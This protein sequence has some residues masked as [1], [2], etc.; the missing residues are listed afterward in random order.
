MLKQPTIFMK[1]SKYSN[2]KKTL[3]HSYFTFPTKVNTKLSYA[4]KISENFPVN[5]TLP[6]FYLRFPVYSA[7]EKRHYIA[8]NKNALCKFFQSRDMK[9]CLH[10][11]FFRLFFAALMIPHDALSEMNIECFINRP[12]RYKKQNLFICLRSSM[13]INY[14]P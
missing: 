13:R 8:W 11:T 12:T 4:P 10:Y 3:L 5:I 6:Q 7:S 1:I 2:I 9:I 14:W